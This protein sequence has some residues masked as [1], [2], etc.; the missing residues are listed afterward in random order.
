M[1]LLASSFD[2]VM[3]STAEQA[4]KMRAIADGDLT[5]VV[6][7]DRNLT[8]LE[9]HCPSWWEKFHGLAGF[10]RLVSNQVDSGA[11]LVARFQ[12]RAFTGAHRKGQ[13]R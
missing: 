10:H 8:Y 1:G 12:H 7:V 9:G 5:T 6:T 2:K 4:Q 3:A 11:K 13:L